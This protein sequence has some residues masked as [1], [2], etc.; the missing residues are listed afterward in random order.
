MDSFIFI[1]LLNLMLVRFYVGIDL[2]S[3][4]QYSLSPVSSSLSYTKLYNFL[5]FILVYKIVLS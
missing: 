2:Y 1:K 4:D 5:I 3:V